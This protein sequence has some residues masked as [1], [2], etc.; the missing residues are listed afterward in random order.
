MPDTG[1]KQTE[2]F[3]MRRRLEAWCTTEDVEAKVKEGIMRRDEN[4]KYKCT[5]KVQLT[6]E[7]EQEKKRAEEA[8]G[9]GQDK[10]Y[11]DTKKTAKKARPFKV[12]FMK[13]IKKA[14]LATYFG[15]TP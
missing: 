12:K 5:A 1:A 9:K 8:K 2:Q 4:G 7:Q 14:N 11:E 13:G 6:K 10:M 15:G 3:I